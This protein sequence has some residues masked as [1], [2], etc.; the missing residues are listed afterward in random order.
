M[1]A[2]KIWCG[3]LVWGFCRILRA[4]HWLRSFVV[5]YLWQMTGVMCFC[6]RLDC[7]KP[8]SQWHVPSRV[9][10][11]AI[12]PELSLETGEGRQESL[13]WLWGRVME[14]ITFVQEALKRIHSHKGV[15]GS[16]IVSSEGIPLRSSTCPTLQ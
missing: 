2:N 8:T 1:G 14:D 11:T 12:I 3:D 6:F 10:V 4:E 9:T 16:I 5:A 7:L 13:S 15:K